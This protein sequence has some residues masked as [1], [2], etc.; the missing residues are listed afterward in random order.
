MVEAGKAE[1][2]GRTEIGSLLL[3]ALWSSG[4][5]R[6]GKIGRVGRVVGSGLGGDG[7]RVVGQ[8]SEL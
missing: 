3:T 6:V 2:T 5:S 8:G 4:E 7:G 1:G